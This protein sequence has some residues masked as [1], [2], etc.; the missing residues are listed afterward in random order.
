MADYA[1]LGIELVTLMPHGDD[2]VAWTERVC[3]EVL[4]GLQQLDH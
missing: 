3:A 1:D 2:P 4:P